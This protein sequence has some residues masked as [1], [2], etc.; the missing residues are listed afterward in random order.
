MIA[1]RRRSARMH[2]PFGDSLVVEMLDLLA[3]DEVFQQRGAPDAG[4]QGV[5]VVADRHAM[6]GRD[7]V[8]RR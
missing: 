5:L 2:D 7:A 3:Q 6:I 1:M 8:V 4:L